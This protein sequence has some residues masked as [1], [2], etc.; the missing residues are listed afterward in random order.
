MSED[1]VVC[2]DKN[3]NE[4][5]WCGEE[6]INIVELLGDEYYKHCIAIILVDDE[7]IDCITITMG[8]S[9]YRYC[10]TNDDDKRHC[11]TMIMNDNDQIY[12]Q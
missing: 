12:H 4:C 8:D 7:N 1:G 2:K 6:Q 3:T 11:I 10:V 9:D 5:L